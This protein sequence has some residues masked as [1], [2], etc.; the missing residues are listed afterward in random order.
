MALITTSVFAVDGLSDAYFV[1]E[2]A[3]EWPN[4]NYPYGVSAHTGDAVAMM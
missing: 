3:A 4:A 1:R 2:T